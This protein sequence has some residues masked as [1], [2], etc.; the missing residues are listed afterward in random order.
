MVAVP[1]GLTKAGSSED[2]VRDLAE[3]EHNF[4]PTTRVSQYN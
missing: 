1:T 2:E 4:Q 3:G